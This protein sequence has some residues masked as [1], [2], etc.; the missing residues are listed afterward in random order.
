MQGN[1]QA[2]DGPSV[3]ASAFQARFDSGASFTS[4]RMAE[5]ADAKD[6]KSF[7]FKAFGFKSRFGH[8]F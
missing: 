2:R 4:A 8:N 3:S 1:L 7:A 6:L 5:L